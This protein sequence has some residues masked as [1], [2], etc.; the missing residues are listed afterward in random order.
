MLSVSAPSAG[1]SGH[2]TVDCR[3]IA[4]VGGR[5]RAASPVEIDKPVS[6]QSG[7]EGYAKQPALGSEVYSQV[8][9]GALT[10]FP[11]TT[12]ST[13]PVFFSSTKHLLE[14]ARVR[15]KRGAARAYDSAAAA[16]ECDAGRGD[17]ARDYRPHLK[18]R[19]HHG[20][21]PALAPLLC[22]R[23]RKS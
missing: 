22:C 15:S 10:R 17:E 13:L 2:S 6:W 23:F 11:L 7:V 12:P 4:R 21:V 3:R 16:E 8:E 5:G 20:W 9:R 19:V 18:V 14:F 1:V